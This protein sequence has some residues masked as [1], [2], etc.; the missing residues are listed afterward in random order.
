MITACDHRSAMLNAHATS[1]ENTHSRRAGHFRVN[2]EV[3]IG[4]RG[5]TAAARVRHGDGDDGRVTPSTSAKPRSVRP[6]RELGGSPQPASASTGHGG[7]A[8]AG[9]FVEHVQL[10]SDSGGSLSTVARI[11]AASPRSLLCRQCHT[12]AAAWQTVTNEATAGQVCWCLPQAA[13]V[14]A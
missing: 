4:G 14:L 10:S 9:Q 13:R 11:P 8:P 6:Q 1:P 7:H 3:Q 12:P 2:N 5:R